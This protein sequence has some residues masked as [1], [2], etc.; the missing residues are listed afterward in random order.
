[1]RQPLLRFLISALA[2][3]TVGAIAFFAVTWVVY[4]GQAAFSTWFFPVVEK[5]DEWHPVSMLFLVVLTL[6]SVWFVAP[7]VISRLLHASESL[8]PPTR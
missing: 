3:L 4:F 6:S 1:M 8:H 2:Y 7:R 5:G